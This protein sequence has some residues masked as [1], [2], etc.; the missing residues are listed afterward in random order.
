MERSIDKNQQGFF[1]FLLISAYLSTSIFGIFY[2]FAGAQ[3]IAITCAIGFSLFAL[4][5]LVS[6]FTSRIVILF[7][8]SIG[9]ALIIFFIQTYLTGGVLSSSMSEFFI[10]SLLAFFYRP[11]KD[12]YV[13]MALS[14]ASMMA[15]WWLTSKGF[16]SNTLHP[17]YAIS[18]SLMSIFFSFSIVVIY[19]FLFRGTLANRNRQLAKSMKDQQVTTQKLIQSEKMASLGVMSA[20]VA[21]EINNPLNFIKGGIDVLAKQLENTKEAEP[22]IKAVEEGVRRASSIVH[23]L[24]HFSRESDAMD[25]V[26]DVNDI[27]DNCLIMLQH[28]LKYKVEVVKEFEKQSRTLT[29]NVGKLHQAFINIISNAE[30]SIEKK[31]TISIKSTTMNEGILV[32]VSDTGTG[33][34]EKNLSKISDPFFTTKAVG[35]GTGLGLSITYEIIRAHGGTID[36]TSEINTGTQFGILFKT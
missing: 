27:L 29:G 15:M 16:V 11:K 5:G 4:Y 34:S 3:I 18:H 14:V 28:K 10:P 20:G 36:V 19:S 35:D 33:I 13:F 1:L 24:G 2:Y 22:F 26:C 6:Y 30:E 21:H 12:R 17:D 32:M 31:G 9:T 23:S 25:E 7:R 8:L